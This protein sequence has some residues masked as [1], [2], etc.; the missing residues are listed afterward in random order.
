MF[1]IRVGTHTGIGNGIGAE[2][3]VVLTSKGDKYIGNIGCY[4]MLQA[5]YGLCIPESLRNVFKGSFFF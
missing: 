4:K 5:A 2:E 1:V 3:F